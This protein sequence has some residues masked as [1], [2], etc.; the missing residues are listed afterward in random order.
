MFV[1]IILGPP[2]NKQQVI[3]THVHPLQK[4]PVKAKAV[5]GKTAV[6]DPEQCVLKKV[7]V[8]N[9]QLSQAKY[10]ARVSCICTGG[11][12]IEMITEDLRCRYL[13]IKSGFR[14]MID[15]A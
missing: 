2:A 9:W 5:T 4:Y 14:C 10:A 13:A 1:C 7:H 6:N 3:S 15:F 12:A 8:P 11:D